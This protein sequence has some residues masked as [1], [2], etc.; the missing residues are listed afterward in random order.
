MIRASERGVILINVL[1]FV[2]IAAG[3]VMLMISAEDVG[4]ERALKMREADRALAIAYGGELSVV[5]ALRRDAIE[6]PLT[7][8]PGEA[9]AA[10]GQRAARIDDGRFELAV[11]DAQ[12]RFNLNSLMSGDVE[13][14]LI[15]DRIAAA[16]ALDPT[17]GA[18]VVEHVRL[19]GPLADLTLL[20]SAGLDSRTVARLL[21]LVTVLP[22]ETPVNANSAS[23]PLLAIVLGDPAAAHALVERRNEAGFLTPDDLAGW[24]VPEEVLS[25][26]SS[27]FWVRTRV[28]IGSTRQ[29]L[30]S[31]V[32]RSARPG[33]RA[34][35]A[36]LAR[37][38]GDGGPPEAPP[39]GP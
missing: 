12:G 25:V 6:S 26:S 34:R 35:V 13:P 14:V 19:N 17:I 20:R 11:A 18:A 33:E 31:L 10:V 1:L 32:Q 22:G 15:L 37:W 28:T 3:L 30:T 27:Y 38:R 16:L 39:L 29:Q 5:S 8:H 9:W 2:A 36:V 4:A 21:A 24:S 7:D 23:E